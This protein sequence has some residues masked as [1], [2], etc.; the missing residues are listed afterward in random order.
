MTLRESFAAISPPWFSKRVAQRYLWSIGLV[1][2]AMKQKMEN[3]IKARFPNVYTD[4]SLADIGNDRLIDRGPTEPAAAYGDRL[5]GAFDTWRSAGNAIKLLENVS[6][7]FAPSLIPIR[8]VDD[9]G[10][11]FEL[12]PTTGAVTRTRPGPTAAPVGDKLRT[13]RAPRNWYW[14]TSSATSATWRPWRAWVVVDASDGRWQQW[15]IGTSQVVLGDGHTLGSTAT[16]DEIA[17]IRRIVKRFKP[18]HV[19]VVNIVVT[20]SATV[21]RATNPPGAPMPSQNYDDPLARS[22]QAIYWQGVDN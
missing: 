21:F 19:H 18:A 2:D 10:F 11:W 6:A 3:G 20:F 9:L 17:S 7:Y 5:S 16:A 8:L 14:D 15:Y 22:T 13:Q 12:D 4:E 1:L